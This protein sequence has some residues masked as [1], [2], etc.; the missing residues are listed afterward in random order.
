MSKFPPA[1]DPPTALNRGLGDVHHV[2]RAALADDHPAG[3][4]ARAHQRVEERR[5]ILL[6]P[7]R[8]HAAR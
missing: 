4:E 2:A 3:I 8:V 6:A 1:G 5:I 7:D